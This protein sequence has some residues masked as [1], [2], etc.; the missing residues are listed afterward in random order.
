MPT[1]IRI[2]N[3]GD[4]TG[5][6]RLV[7]A[8]T[9]RRP[10]FSLFNSSV[11]QGSK[12]KLSLTLRRFSND[13]P[14][15]LNPDDE[16]CH[17][18]GSRSYSDFGKL[19]AS[20]TCVRALPAPCRSFS[21]TKPNTSSTQ[22]IIK[23]LPTELSTLVLQYCDLQSILAAQQ[24]S[25]TWYKLT[26]QNQIWHSL[27]L[28]R[29]TWTIPTTPTDQ[30][31][32]YADLYRRRTALVHRWRKGQVET[33]YLEGHQDSVYCLQ[34]DSDKIVSGSR[35]KNIKIWDARSYQCTQTL[36]GHTASVLCLR[37]NGNTL[38]SG[39][40]DTTVRVWDL[41]TSECTMQLN[42][43]SS[44]V[45]DV[46]F[47]E[48]YIISCS[49][50][51]SI[52]VWDRTTGDHVATLN[53]HRGPVNSVQVC[54]RQLVSAAGDGL[55]KLWDLDTLD[56]KRDFTGH[57]R[58]LACVQFDGNRIL[59]GSNDKKIKVW[60]AHTGECT[61]TLEG[62]EDLVRTLSFNEVECCRRPP[63]F[64]NPGS[65]LL[66]KLLYRISLSAEVMTKL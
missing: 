4:G 46:C 6:A 31:I 30:I 15:S 25:R 45:L 9:T 38:V 34:F 41:D 44:G 1:R 19:S 2:K 7:E 14:K 3:N 33:R 57:T 49:K 60:D 28:Q 51:T 8:P 26:K 43:H 53:G 24:V 35:D 61:M 32:D 50:D 52:R 21:P 12:R 65:L 42:G 22:D 66:T 16:G 48:Q 37:Y 63:P 11:K 18:Q 64:S 54:G 40:S 59:S 36:R 29:P 27:L 56:L 13:P 62:H 58:G 10:S 5:T 20:V 23:R 47:N 17:P 39:S 55:V